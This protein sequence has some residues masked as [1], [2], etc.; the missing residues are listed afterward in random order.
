M[1]GPDFWTR[2]RLED[3]IAL[4]QA[5]MKWY[6]RSLAIIVALAAVLSAVFQGLSYF[7]R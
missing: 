1:H 5:S 6:W 2:A 7:N 4:Q 3:L